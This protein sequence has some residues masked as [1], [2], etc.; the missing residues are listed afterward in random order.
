MHKGF[1]NRKLNEYKKG[2]FTIIGLLL[3]ISCG[4]TVYK[5]SHYTFQ[6]PQKDVFV[7][8]SKRPGG[9]FIVF[10]AQDSLS[11]NNSKDSIEFKT[12]ENTVSMIVSETDVYLRTF[13]PLGLKDTGNGKY[14]LVRMAYPSD[15]ESIGRNK[16]NIEILPDS[17][18]DTFYEKNPEYTLIRINTRGYNIFINQK[19]IKKGNIHGE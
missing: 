19:Q 7:K 4:E 3:I 2:I 18:F 1:M 5:E 11:L 17:I 6:L 15:I 12:E 9:K 14:Q 10:F 8:T 16:F 13:Y